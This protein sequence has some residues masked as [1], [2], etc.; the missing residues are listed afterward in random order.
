MTKSLTGSYWFDIC[1]FL[2]AKFYELD[3]C[4]MVLR[5]HLR[6][7]FANMLTAQ[8]KTVQ[9]V[10]IFFHFGTNSSGKNKGAMINRGIWLDRCWIASGIGLE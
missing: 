9:P 1:R 8:L 6:S 5:M 2:V 7:K 3:H 4:H 10:N